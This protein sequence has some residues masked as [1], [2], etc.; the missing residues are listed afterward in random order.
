MQADPT[1]ARSLPRDSFRR[2]ADGKSERILTRLFSEADVRVDG[3]RPEDIT[4]HDGDFFTRVLRDGSLGFGESYMDGLWDCEALDT[5]TAKLV[6]ADLD[7]KVKGDWRS[8]LHVL[9][10]KGLNLQATR[11]AFEV[12]ERHYDLGNDLYQ[13]MLDS[14]MI[15]SC[16]YWRDAQDLEGA[17]VAKLDL[18]CQKVGLKPGMKV[19][20]IGCG[21]GGF[22]RYAAERYGVEV[23]GITVSKEQER[24]AADACAGL[25]VDIRLEDY[26]TTT[27]SY[28]AIVSIGMFEHVGYKNYRTFMEVMHRLL[29]DDG[30]A[31]LHTIGGNRSM[32]A[33]NPWFDRYI[34]PNAL[35]PSLT[36]A[37]SGTEEL[38]SVED[39]QNLGP[40]Y[41]PTLLAWYDNF[42]RAWPRLEAKYGERFRR[43][44]R[45]YLL[46]SAGTARARYLQLYQIV[47]TK[48]GREQP[49]CRV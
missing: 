6:R 19:L 5:L 22:A 16:G 49:D 13:A 32:K 38:F 46:T 34:F 45:Y 28:D 1:Q 27:G 33:V 30:I 12:G 40:D 26:R 21:W 4:V 39:V 48:I 7:K 31:L 43:M 15:Y 10:A 37:V 36:Q 29:K 24:L 9:R 44:W 23:T 41:D 25:P 2:T 35:I 20:D 42:E 3:Q 17:Q 47:L 18:V 11:R 14:R 8:V